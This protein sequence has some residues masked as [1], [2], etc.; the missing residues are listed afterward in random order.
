MALNRLRL[1]TATTA[2]IALAWGGG[3]AT[4]VSKPTPVERPFASTSV[5]NQSLSRD[6]RPTRASQ[7]L[8][9][10]LET[11]VTR[12]GATI[13][14][15]TYSTPVYRVSAG[16]RRVRVRL[17]RPV[18]PGTSPYALARAF[19]AVP[20]PPSARPAAGSDGHMV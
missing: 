1:L 12:F 13:A 20:I 7:R 15:T 6:L 17:D 18:Y 8:V 5:W 4:G 10:G 2:T 11:Q 19:R 9:T 3:T 16:Q 14:T